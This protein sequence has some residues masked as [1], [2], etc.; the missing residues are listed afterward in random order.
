MEEYNQATQMGKLMAGLKG[1]PFNNPATAPIK[2]FTFAEGVPAESIQVST[3]GMPADGVG[4]MID[5]WGQRHR[6]K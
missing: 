1:G 2:K 6:A 4:T 3:Q 5:P